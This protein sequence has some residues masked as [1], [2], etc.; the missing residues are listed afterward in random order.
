ML[1]RIFFALFFSLTSLMAAERA[2][3]NTFDGNALNKGDFEIE[4]WLWS[5]DT[6]NGDNVGWIWFGPVYGLSKNV[7]I[8][9]PWEMVVT[10]NGTQLSN[11]NLEARIKLYDSLNHS[12]PWYPMIRLFVQQNFHKPGNIRRDA[13]WVGVNA[14]MSY[15]NP[16]DSHLAVD[17]GYIEDIAYFNKRLKRN[18]LGVGYSHRI[19]ESLSLGLEYFHQVQLG[20]F[21]EHFQEY[22]L[23]PNVAFK[24]GQSWFTFGFQKGLNDKSPEF[25]SRLMFGVN[26]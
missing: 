13:P 8:A 23:G 2:F 18:T 19:D 20:D 21:N 17:I 22:L 11:F 10:K 4:Q 3:I 9:I 12:G 7:E 25:L 15:G 14:I 1:R 5:F 24:R 26:I 16:K 6:Q